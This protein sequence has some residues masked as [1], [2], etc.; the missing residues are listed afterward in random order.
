M[1]HYIALLLFIFS[2]A[3]FAKEIELKQNE[4]PIDDLQLFTT[5]IE[6]VKNYYV[7]PTED[8][9][10]FE[11]AIR[12]MLTGLDPHSAYLDVDEFSDL[13]VSTSGKFGGLGIEVTMEDGFIRIISPIDDTPADKAGIQPGDLIIRLDD[14][15][16]KG[17]SLKEAV[18][19]M[20]GKQGS[21]ILLTII[22][23][24]QA[25]PVKVKIIRD[26]IN[27]KSVKNRVLEPG[28]GYIRVSQFQDDSGDEQNAEEQKA[29]E[30]DEE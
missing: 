21:P 18:D 1:K 15:P 10:L 26:I 2:T 29:E 25:K 19:M 11:G 20:R 8:N 6:H 30:Q 17:L 28:Y 23:K 13:K 9:Q 5:V 27:V 4:I 3:S 16:V 14:T 22:R 7:N 12:G 24:G